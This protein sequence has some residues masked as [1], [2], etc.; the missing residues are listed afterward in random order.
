[1]AGS[2][3]SGGGDFDA[4]LAEINVTP[5][6]DVMLVLLVIFIV[7]APLMAQ[8]LKVDLPR[9][10]APSDA[11]PHVIALVAKADGVTLLDDVV[12][13]SEALEAALKARFADNPQ[14]VLRLGADA[15][16]AYEEVARLLSIAQRAGIRRIAFATRA[17]P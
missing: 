16:I 17:A 4:P 10:A 3:S 7:A 14:A 8:A 6:V 13:E 1:M 12:I 5:L 2:S 15:A 9:A 11:E